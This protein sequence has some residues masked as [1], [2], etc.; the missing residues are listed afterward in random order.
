MLPHCL[1]FNHP[2]YDISPKYKTIITFYPFFSSYQSLTAKLWYYSTQLAII[3]KSNRNEEDVNALLYALDK[4]IH[5]WHVLHAVLYGRYDCHNQI[6]ICLKIISTHMWWERRQSRS[7]MLH[8]SQSM[9]HNYFHQW[10]LRYSSK[11]AA[12][13]P[14]WHKLW[15]YSLIFCQGSHDAIF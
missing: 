4:H 11:H 12:H 6:L 8:L 2:N 13:L 9:P 1:A 14:I 15:L 10:Q 7:F 3:T 5:T